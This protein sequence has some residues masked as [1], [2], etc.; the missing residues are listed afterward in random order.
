M[1]HLKSLCSLI[2]LSILLTGCWDSR[3]I[4]DISL[5]IGVGIDLEE[6]SENISLGHQIIVPPSNG[7]DSS[8]GSPSKTSIL[9]VKQCMVL[10][11]IWHYET[12]LFIVI[13]NEFCLF[14]TMF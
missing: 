1:K 11:E 12:I 8:Q 9:Q 13:T 6:E 3:S 5:V 10:F 14:I 2:G 4:E 7:G